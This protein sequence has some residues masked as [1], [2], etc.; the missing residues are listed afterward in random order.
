VPIRSPTRS[1]LFLAALL[2][3]VPASRLGAQGTAPV[4]ASDLAYRDVDRLAELG[5][6]DSVILAQRPYSRREMARVARLARARLDQPDDRSSERA[7]EVNALVA[8][9]LTRFAR[10]DASAA[11]NGPRID[12][13]DGAQLAVVSTDA[14]RRGFSGTYSDRLE[15]TIDPLAAPRR[16]GLPEP[17][18]QS[19]ALELAQRVE[20]TSWLAFY[21]RE[22]V[23]ALL[24]GQ[25]SGDRTRGALLR[26]GMRLR[27]GNVAVNVGRD[28][29][30]W[31]SSSDD[32][33]FLAAD[34]PALD[35][36]SLAGDQPFIL[37]GFLR[38]LGPTQATLLLADLGPSAVRSHSMLL[39]YKVSVQPRPT[40]ELGASFMNHFG[41]RGAPAA[42]FGNRVI[43]FLP[44]VDIF[45][46]HNYTD[47]TRTLDVESDKL[48][49]VSGRWRIDR[50][51]GLTLATE[52]LIDDF[53]VHRIPTLFGWD[54]SQTFAATLPS[55]ARSPLAVQLSA[56]HMGVRT[57]TH[58]QLSNGITTRGQLL[59]DELGPDAK[60]FGAVLTWHASGAMRFGVDAR[61]ALYSKSEY[62]VVQEGDRFTNHRVGEVTNELRDRLLASLEFQRPDGMALVAR[63]GAERIRNADF[64]DARRHSFVLDV[65]LRFA[66]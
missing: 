2:I 21:A 14:V 12:L 32:G 22:R 30:A 57:Y 18:G 9:L 6:L 44:F 65:A 63:A 64:T 62:H 50:L 3:A 5:V 59:G 51:A 61:T 56:T 11:F 54:G 49:G 58:G 8:R 34:A 45:R 46:S 20:A 10:D 43:D 25:T 33:L 55:V 29:L 35:Q 26:A 16:I 48:L 42:S 52:L 19:A 4:P 27:A 39:A 1:W 31:A 17:H 37:P 13:M 38:A 36:I 47:S 15:A 24:S 7:D 53:D 60:A 28:Q 40:L 23:E 66:R 41:G